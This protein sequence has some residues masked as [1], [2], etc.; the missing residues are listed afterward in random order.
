MDVDHTTSS[1]DSSNE[2]IMDIDN[3]DNP[4]DIL[5]STASDMKKTRSNNQ[6]TTTGRETHLREILESALPTGTVVSNEVLSRLSQALATIIDETSEAA[7]RKAV[8]QLSS[9]SLGKRSA[10]AIKKPVSKTANTKA[11]N[12][13][14]SNV[15]RSKKQVETDESEEEEY[16]V[17]SILSHKTGR[18]G[19]LSFQIKWKG[20]PAS[21]STWE[22]TGAL[23][24]CK[25]L[26]K[27]YAKKHKLSL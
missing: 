5:A 22:D 7:A 6:A 26:L 24:G 23:A 11:A 4:L 12:G 13:K 17:E 8:G 3:E 27:E 18:N 2:Q 1:Q 10:P 9:K 25:D 21:Q 14:N 16:E 20:Y 19:K 15:S